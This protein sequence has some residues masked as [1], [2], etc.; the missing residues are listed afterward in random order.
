MG[1]ITGTMLA[2]GAGLALA[3]AGA[4]IGAAALMGGGKKQ[5]TPAVQMPASP[6]VP[7]LEDASAK[8]NLA[9]EERR[10]AMARSKSV[11]TN[12]LGVQDEANVARKKLLGG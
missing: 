10:R 9:A 6:A 7:K 5:E 12:P 11:Q 1:A 2:V 3:G 8:A 4:G